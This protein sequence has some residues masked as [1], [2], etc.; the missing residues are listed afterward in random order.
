MIPHIQN[1]PTL[2]TNIF[3]KNLDLIS[4]SLVFSINS[5]GVFE[6]DEVKKQVITKFG[7]FKKYQ[8]IA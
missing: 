7:E 3:L 4:K 1:F 5:L 6:F 8:F 2:S